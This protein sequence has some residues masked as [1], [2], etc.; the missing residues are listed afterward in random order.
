MAIK[1]WVYYLIGLNLIAAAVVLN[2]RFDL[3]VAAFSSVMYA[4]AEIYDISMGTASILCYLLF[5]ALQCLL[6][7][8]A[9]MNVL[10]E[11][12]LS[13]AFG[14]LIDIYDAVIPEMALS[15][16]S[17]FVCFALTLFVTALGVFFCVK[18]DLVL[19]PIEGIVKTI[20]D[21]FHLRFSLVKNSFDL[22]MVIVSV[23]LCL[24]NQAPFYGIGIGTVLSAIFIG[25]I[26]RI[27]EGHVLVH[28]DFRQPGGAVVQH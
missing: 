22:S 24:V 10:L 20:S 2:I 18:T 11:I 3:G 16:V 9:T 27:Y 15:V 25:R 13:F 17:A 5:V 8:R 28:T 1:R 7:R 26:I 12:P 14:I 6:L 21:V 19:T 23:I 4:I